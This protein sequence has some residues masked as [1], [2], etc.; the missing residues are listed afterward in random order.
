[1][2]TDIKRSKEQQFKIIQLGGFLG[3]LLGKLAST[4]I[5]VIVLLAKNILALL[6]IMASASAIDGTVRRRMLGRGV[7]R[8][9]KRMTLVI[10]NEDK[11]DILQ[12]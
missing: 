5:K 12:P 8:A 2:S 7:V 11:D 6:A 4:L 9:R 10:S 1:M 3:S